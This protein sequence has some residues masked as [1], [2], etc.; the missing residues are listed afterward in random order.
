MNYNLMSN[1][2]FFKKILKILTTINKLLFLHVI[3]N[4]NLISILVF[5]IIFYFYIFLI[6]LFIIIIIII[7]ISIKFK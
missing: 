1:F 2:F 5:I 4:S 3:I 6:F 7:N